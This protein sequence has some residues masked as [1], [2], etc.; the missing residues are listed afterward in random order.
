[1]PMIEGLGVIKYKSL[2]CLASTNVLCILRDFF[3]QCFRERERKR[4]RERLGEREEIYIFKKRDYC[5]ILRYFKK[6]KKHISCL[7]C[8]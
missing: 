1:M 3:Y 8:K 4:E 7:A 6:D 2:L 5:S